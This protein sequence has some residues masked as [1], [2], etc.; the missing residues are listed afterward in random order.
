MQNEIRKLEYNYN[1]EK[2]VYE[3]KLNKVLLRFIKS[4]YFEF[5]KNEICNHVGK[6]VWDSISFN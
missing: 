3:E 6:E 1:K 2:G 4:V 5:D